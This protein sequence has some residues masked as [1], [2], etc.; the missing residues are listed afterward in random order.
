MKSQSILYRCAFLFLAAILLL[1]ACGDDDENQNPENPVLHVSEDTLTFFRQ[2]SLRLFLHTEPTSECSYSFTEKPEWVT[3]NPT[4]GTIGFDIEE[5]IITASSYHL[6]YGLNTG[7]IY[8]TTP[9]GSKNICVR[10][11]NSYNSTYYTL[12]DSV[13]IDNNSIKTYLTIKNK[14]LSTLNFALECEAGFAD[15]SE[16]SGIVADGQNRNIEININRNLMS[17]GLYRNYIHLT[18]NNKTEHIPFIVENFNTNKLLLD[19]TVTDAEYSKA[20]DKLI[21]VSTNPPTLGIYNPK[22]RKLDKKELLYD[23]ICLSVSSDGTTAVIGHDALITYFDLVNREILRHYDISCVAFDIILS[24]NQWTYVFPKGS[25]HMEKEKI[26]CIDLSTTSSIEMLSGGHEI[27]G[28]S[29]GRL[30]PS[31]NSIYCANGLSYPKCGKFDISEGIAVNQYQSSYNQ[32]DIKGNLWL[33]EEGTRLFTNRNIAYKTAELFCNDF[34]YDGEIPLSEASGLAMPIIESMDISGIS[35]KLFVVIANTSA[36]HEPLDAYIFHSESL[37]Y[38]KSFQLEKYIYEDGSGYKECN[39]V[40]KFIF[41]NQNGD[42]FYVITKPDENDFT[43]KW[44]IQTFNLNNSQYIQLRT[45][46]AAI[47]RNAI[48]QVSTLN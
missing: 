21:F 35:K 24:N 7:N 45:Q 41:C 33:S 15:F 39:A 32:V 3:I 8:L 18:I 13:Y 20:I 23:P 30:H 31:G 34:E 29:K 4:S 44:S 38:E 46:T 47:E 48:F 42:E 37:I 19:Q 2:D 27:Y 43:E 28:Y 10:Y 1:S 22:S 25:Y 12:P 16:K 5:I 14:G 11:M 36:N 17:T 9:F 26:H 6:N 40:P